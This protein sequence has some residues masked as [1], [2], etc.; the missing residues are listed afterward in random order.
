MQRNEIDEERSGAGAIAGHRYDPTNDVR[1]Y[2]DFLRL[3]MP[4]VAS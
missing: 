3:A 4:A 2:D 1:D